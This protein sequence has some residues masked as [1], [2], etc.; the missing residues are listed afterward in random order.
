MFVSALSWSTGNEVGDFREYD[1]NLLDDPQWP[2]GKHKRV[3]IFPSYMASCCWCCF[4]YFFFPSPFSHRNTQNTLSLSHRRSP[5]EK[6]LSRLGQRSGL[7]SW[8]HKVT[9]VYFFFCRSAAQE[10][11]MTSGNG[12]ERASLRPAAWR[13]FHPISRFLLARTLC[14][15]SRSCFPRASR[16]RLQKKG[17]R[18][19]LVR[20][21]RKQCKSTW[22]SG[23]W[24]SS[25]ARGSALM[26]RTGGQTLSLMALKWLRWWLDW[27]ESRLD[28]ALSLFFFFLFFV[29]HVITSSRSR[30]ND[31]FIVFT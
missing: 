15:S 2:C 19:Q 6:L 20:V 26:R 1:P 31:F 27:L 24:T 12:P 17:N 23:V 3:L 8:S 22:C 30:G 18:K 21:Q 14:S 29:L 7:I 5:A 28:H 11:G 9:A 13:R 16:I 4:V 25:Q 10:F